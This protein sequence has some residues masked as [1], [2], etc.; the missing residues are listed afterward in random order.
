MTIKFAKILRF[1]SADEVCNLL[2]TFVE[3]QQWVN[4]HD[5]IFHNT[6][7]QSLVYRDTMDHCFTTH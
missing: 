2:C 7:E 5:N 4:T 1:F 6:Q 3:V